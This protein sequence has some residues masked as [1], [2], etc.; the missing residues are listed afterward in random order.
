MSDYFATPWTLTCQAP[1]SMG[2][3][4]ARIL[5]WVAI[6]FSRGSSWPRDQTHISCL[7]GKFFTTEPPGKPNFFFFCLSILHKWSQSHKLALFD[8]DYFHEWKEKVLC[9]NDPEKNASRNLSILRNECKREFNP[10]Y[11]FK[12]GNFHNIFYKSL[13]KCFLIMKRVF[14]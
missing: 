7:A 11:G 4:Q 9:S 2:F 3:S 5:E 10:Y 8:C 6:P 1:L 12:Q 13:G 14:S